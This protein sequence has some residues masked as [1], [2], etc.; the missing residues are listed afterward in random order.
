MQLTD[1]RLGYGQ[2]RITMDHYTMPPTCLDGS[3]VTCVVTLGQAI[4]YGNLS[5][6]QFLKFEKNINNQDY[7][8]TGRVYD[9]TGVISTSLGVVK[10]VNVSLDNHMMIVADS[11]NNN[12]LLGLDI[13]LNPNFISYNAQWQF[14]SA[15]F[16]GV[17]TN[18]PNALNTAIANAVTNAVIQGAKNGGIQQ[19]L[20]KG[21]FTN[22]KFST[23]QVLN[24]TYDKSCL[25]NPDCTIS[26][27]QKLQ[28]KATVLIN[29]ILPGQYLKFTE[30][31]TKAGTYTVTLYDNDETSRIVSKGGAFPIASTKIALFVDTTTKQGYLLFAQVEPSGSFWLSEDLVENMGQ[32]NKE[33]ALKQN[34]LPSSNSSQLNKFFGKKPTSDDLDMFALETY[35]DNLNDNFMTDYPT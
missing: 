29:D 17:N 6:G 22:T 13:L 11:N 33:C 30:I 18:E 25:S 5:N 3:D 8:Y 19:P 7:P 26:I 34:C 31:V 15:A 2:V 16:Q 23:S 32:Y 1:M 27:L 12:V 28:S 20:I 21:I 4:K 10:V 35:L 9:K 24:A 14:Q